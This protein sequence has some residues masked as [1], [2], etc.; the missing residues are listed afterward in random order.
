MLFAHP[1]VSKGETLGHTA[2]WTLDC[3]QLDC[4]RSYSVGPYI[5][6][7]LYT[8]WTLFRSRS[9]ISEVICKKRSCDSRKSGKLEPKKWNQRIGTEKN[10][11][12]NESK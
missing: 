3:V 5:A 9:L 6:L 12:Q 7:E 4:V 8:R 10:E 1:V 2:V 11:N